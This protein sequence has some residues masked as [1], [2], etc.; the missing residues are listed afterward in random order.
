M[1]FVVNKLLPPDHLVHNPRVA[2][3]DLHH[4]SAHVLIHVIRHGDAMVAILVHLHG[5]VNGLKEA[6]GVDTC[7]EE[8]TLV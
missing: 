7:D 3:D 1:S 8:T 2:L 6:I 4:L 5:A